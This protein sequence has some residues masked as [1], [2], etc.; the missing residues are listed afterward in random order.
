MNTKIT[1]TGIILSCFI[2]IYLA[3]NLDKVNNENNELKK[4]N[5]ILYLK[6]EYYPKQLDTIRSQVKIF[7]SFEINTTRDSMYVD[8][9]L[10]VIQ[11]KLE[12]IVIELDSLN[13]YIIPKFIQNIINDIKN[14]N[15]LTEI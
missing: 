6:Y 11:N 14:K 5:E 12:L 4:Y 1:Y 7:S 8:S 3:F 10:I 15:K 13:K 9:N 2:S